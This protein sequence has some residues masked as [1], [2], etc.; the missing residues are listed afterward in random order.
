MPCI[1]GVEV[2]KSY[3]YQLYTHCGIRWAYFDQRW[4]S[5]NPALD[6]GNRNPPPGWG[7]PSDEGTMKLVGEERAVFT[8]RSGQTAEFKSLPRNVQEFPGEV[9]Y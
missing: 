6:D 8:A 3:P 9:C 2:G 4:W 7:N 5:A 1:S